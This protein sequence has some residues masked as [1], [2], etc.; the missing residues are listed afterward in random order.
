MNRTEWKEKSKE[1]KI[2]YILGCILMFILGLTNS[3]L[4]IIPIM[5][6]PILTFNIILLTFIIIRKRKRK[7]K[8][9]NYEF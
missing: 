6:F 2:G 4:M 5:R 7:R 1:Y 3:L 8:E 9:N